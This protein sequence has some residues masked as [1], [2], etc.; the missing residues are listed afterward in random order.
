MALVVDEL[1]PADDLSGV[2]R[3]VARIEP[4]DGHLIA[5]AYDQQGQGS[6]RRIERGRHRSG[7]DASKGNRVDVASRALIV[8]GER[9]VADVEHI[10]VVAVAAGGHA[11][12]MADGEN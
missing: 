1:N 12:F 10:D 4:G 2:F 5:G 6:A 3:G 7:I 8:D 9:A 11:A